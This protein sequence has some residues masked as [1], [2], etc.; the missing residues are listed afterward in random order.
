M[1]N[2][3]DKKQNFFF[4]LWRVVYPL[5]IHYGMLF[6]V[7]FIGMLVITLMLT[8]EYSLDATIGNQFLNEYFL[9]NE[10]MKALTKSVTVLTGL[11]NLCACPLLLLFIHLDNKKYPLGKVLNKPHAATFILPFL[12]G[13]FFCIIGNNLILITDIDRLT[14]GSDELSVLY[15]GNIF[16]EILMIGIIAPI[17]EELAFRALAYRRMRDYMPAWLSIILSSLIFGIYHGNLIQ[18]IYAFILGLVLAYVYEKYKNILAPILVHAAA[19]TL[20]VTITETTIFD[21]MYMS[22]TTV[23]IALIVTTVLGAATIVTIQL[24][25]K[26]RRGE[27]P[28]WPV[29]TRPEQYIYIQPQPMP[30]PYMQTPP[31]PYSYTQV[32]PV[33]YPYTQ[34]MPQQTQPVQYPCVPNVQPQPAQQV[35]YPYAPNIWIQPQP[36]QQ[37][38][39]PYAPNTWQQPQPVQQVQYLYAP[40]TWQQPQPTQQVQ[41]PYSPNTWQQPQPTQPVQPPNN[42]QL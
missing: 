26:P 29:Q 18:G 28:A 33:Q 34:N 32:P 3:Q 10:L 30:Y 11:A 7:T 20:S 41:Y 35:Q 2:P 13:L 16:V 1:R 5:G 4:K 38:Q 27:R 21:F 31:V 36:T 37:V 15:G 39:Y 23:L 8:A 22:F 42:N 24:I 14:G 25:V 12:A 9:E 17:G 6:I 19:N 40:N